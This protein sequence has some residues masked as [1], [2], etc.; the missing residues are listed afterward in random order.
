MKR[1]IAP[2]MKRRDAE[3]GICR[4][5]KR[6][7]RID[8]DGVRERKRKTEEKV[9]ETYPIHAAGGLLTIKPPAYAATSHPVKL[10]I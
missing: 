9:E 4:F 1:M 6:A 5:L 2:A 7:L 3:R 10:P 8:Q